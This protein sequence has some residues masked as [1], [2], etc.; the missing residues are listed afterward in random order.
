MTCDIYR[1][2][3]GEQSSRMKAKTTLY[4]LLLD[5]TWIVRTSYDRCRCVC[6]A[7]VFR[8]R[9]T[10]ADQWGQRIE[11]LVTLDMGACWW[12]TLAWPAADSARAR[13]DKE[14]DWT[15]EWQQSLGTTS[16]QSGRRTTTG[17][18]FSD[19][20]CWVTSRLQENMVCRMRKLVCVLRRDPD[21]SLAF[22]IF[23][24]AACY[25]RKTFKK[26]SRK[27]LRTPSCCCSEREHNHY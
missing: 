13:G 7:S 2:A 21:K 24:F 10:G 14:V 5:A 22:H 15:S 11:T 6:L 3:V 9:E 26:A 4:I 23:L 19:S 16:S 27:F 12:R 25:E 1:T 17:F 18:E 8:V 20:L